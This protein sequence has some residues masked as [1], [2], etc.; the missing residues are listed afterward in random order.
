MH[1]QETLPSRVRIGEIATL[2]RLSGGHFSRAFKATFG[3][4]FRQYVNE[5]RIEQAKLMMLTSEESLAE[6]AIACG[7]ADQSHFTRLFH[8][9]VG[10]TPNAWRRQMC[11]EERCS[12]AAPDRPPE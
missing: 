4:S 6:I 3:I 10:I 2:V 7:T 1:I 5:C 9:L 8:R 11:G 12:L